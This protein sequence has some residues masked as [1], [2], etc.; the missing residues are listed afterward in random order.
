MYGKIAKRVAQDTGYQENGK[1]YGNHLPNPHG[2][3]LFRFNFPEKNFFT[4][5]VSK[6]KHRF[7][8]F[9]DAV[10]KVKTA[11]SLSLDAITMKLS[12][13]L[14]FPSIF[15]ITSFS[16]IFFRRDG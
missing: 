2:M 9:E 7:P 4:F 6:I 16:L 11:M 1:E 13:L 12:K 5:R 10:Q 8:P 15:K 3:F 14:Y